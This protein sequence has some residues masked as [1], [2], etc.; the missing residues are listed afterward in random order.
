MYC[1]CVVD[2][3]YKRRRPIKK[4]AVVYIRREQKD[5]INR[6]LQITNRTSFR[7]KSRRKVKSGKEY[8]RGY[9]NT[10]RPGNIV[11]NWV[12]E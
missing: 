5:P 6:C 4:G 8:K 9:R 3:N 10:V 7:T 1:L 2:K 12:N 11:I